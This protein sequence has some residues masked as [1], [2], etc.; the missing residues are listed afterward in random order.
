M[1]SPLAPLLLGSILLAVLV[2]S[3]ALQKS[4]ISYNDGI[5][6]LAATGHQEAYSESRPIDRAGWK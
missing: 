3:G 5:T 6:Y 1:R 2:V 4:S